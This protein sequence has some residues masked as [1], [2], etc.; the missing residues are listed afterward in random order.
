LFCETVGV[1]GYKLKFEP[2]VNRPSRSDRILRHDATIPLYFHL[3]IVPWQDRPAEIE[4]VSK[5]FRL[6]TVIEILGDVCL[7]DARPA[8]T[9]GA[10][11]INELLRD[12]SHLGKVKVRW[13]LFA[14]RQ[15]ETREGC[16]MRPEEGFELM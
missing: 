8:I 1:P 2:V 6:E 3:E 15:N 10:A 9:E 13:N 7:Q 16:G 14:V 5:A 11:T 4:D 12:I